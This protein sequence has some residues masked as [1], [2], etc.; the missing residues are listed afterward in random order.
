[1]HRIFLRKVILLTQF[2]T[3]EVKIYPVNAGTV[4][5]ADEI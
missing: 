5:A 4:A 1:L 2:Y 3:D